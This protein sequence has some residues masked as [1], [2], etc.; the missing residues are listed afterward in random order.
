MPSTQA[1]RTDMTRHGR[2]RHSAGGAGDCIGTAR[3][4]DGGCS[5]DCTAAPRRHASRRHQ[6]APWSGPLGPCGQSPPAVSRCHCVAVGGTTGQAQ[7]WGRG[8]GSGQIKRPK[9]SFIPRQPALKLTPWLGGGQ[10]PPRNTRRHRQDAYPSPRT[11]LPSKITAPSRTRRKACKY[12]V[13]RGLDG[14]VH[15]NIQASVGQYMSGA[16]RGPFH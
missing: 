8:R 14:R 3:G 7:T 12:V 2:A 9:V 4:F 16:E 11:R 1:S 15:C 6:R 13:V 5:T 10:S